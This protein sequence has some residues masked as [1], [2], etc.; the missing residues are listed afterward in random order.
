[1][2]CTSRAPIALIAVL[3]LTFGC[4]E[5]T[6][7]TS[8]VVERLAADRPTLTSTAAPTPSPQIEPIAAG[9]EQEDDAAALRTTVPPAPVLESHRGLRIE[10]LMTASSIADRE[11]AMVSSVFGSGEARVYA[12]IEASNSS[13]EDRSLLVHFIGPGGGVSGGVQLEVP[14]SAPRWRTWAFTRHAKS[15]GIWRV[16]IRDAEGALV[17]VV[18]FEVQPDC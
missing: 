12:F 14:A 10:R 4:R 18:P 16:E 9:S 11:P 17:G 3:W 7:E 13:D 5:S 8:P 1:M 15:P 6:T 2:H